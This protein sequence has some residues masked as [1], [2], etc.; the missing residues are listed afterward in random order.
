M[1][2]LAAQDANPAIISDE[3]TLINAAY[4][5]VAALEARV[6]SLSITDHFDRYFLTVALVGGGF[7]F[8]EASETKFYASISGIQAPHDAFAAL[9]TTL[10]L[11]HHDVVDNGLALT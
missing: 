9:V 7:L 1:L 4:A 6:A 5:A 2:I 3:L 10:K 11:K 8:I